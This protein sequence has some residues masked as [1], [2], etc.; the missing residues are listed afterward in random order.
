MFSIGEFSMMSGIPVR[1]LRFYHEQGLLVP[2][3][4][5]PE[6]NYRS[7]DARNLERAN[8]IVALRQLEFPLDDIREILAGAADD[9]DILSYLER[10]KHLLTEKLQHYQNVV[11]TIDQVI[12]QECESRKENAMSTTKSEIRTREVGPLLV[13]G[14]RT[15]GKYSDCGQGFAKLGRRLGRHIAGKPLCLYYD[16]EYREGDANF[17]PCM[18]IRKAVEAEGFIVR[19][20]PA[21]TCITL[22]RYGPYEELRRSYA[23]LMKYVKDQGYEISLPTREVYLKGPG[24]IFRGNP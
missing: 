22:T 11:A 14:I 7:Y 18:P 24:M 6:S 10:Q 9:A 1:T 2:A 4:I 3:A 19:E 20:L 12:E 21:A 23:R 16:G 17:E 15:Q 13:A 5:D 8:V